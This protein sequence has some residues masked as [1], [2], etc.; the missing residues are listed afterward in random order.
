MKK[1]MLIILDGWGEGRDYPGNAVLAANTP[2]Y[3]TFVANNPS[4][5]LQ[6]SGLSVGLPE[7]QMGNSEVGHLTI[8]AGRV[9]Y[10]E[11]TRINHAFE[12]AEL[13]TNQAFIDQI[14]YCKTQGKPIHLLGLLS[15]GGVH[16]HIQHLFKTIA[17]LDESGVQNIYIHAF[18]DGRDTDPNS[19]LGHLKSLYDFIEDCQKVKIASAIG[20]Y[21]AM[22]RDNRWERTAKAYNLL[23]G[24]EGE[25][26]ENL[27][28]EIDQQ[29][30]EGIT[31]EFMIPFK[32]H[33][34][35]PIQEGDAVLFFNFR[36]DRGRQ[37]TKALTQ[38]D[39]THSEMKPFDSLYFSTFTLYDK[40]FEGVHIIFEPQSLENTLGKVLSDNGLNQ[41]R[42][43]ETEK[44]PHVTFFFN[45]QIEAPY[46][47]EHRF[48]EPSPKVATYDL[49]PEMSAAALNDGVIKAINEEEFSFA[50]VNFANPDMVGHT[51]VFPAIVKACE[52][53]DFE[54]GKLMAE[55]VRLDYQI[56]ITADHGNAEVAINQDNTPN[57]A[58]STNLVRLIMVNSDQIFKSTTGSLADL[59]P[60]ILKM[61][62]V[63]IPK[64][65]TGSILV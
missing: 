4:I 32:T 37:L 14:D 48:L 23:V 63:A 64:E 6:A 19:G 3:D 7:G 53:V 58:H 1:V 24:K 36:T 18:L 46:I 38:K 10:Q 9:V 34:F 40:A 59:A 31:D 13:V 45:G 17:L 8:G 56:L 62:E 61:I 5:M 25:L 39:F 16:S 60:T 55:A 44:Y 65:M 57:T 35:A 28:A 21:Y 20:R 15:D 11:L 12:T 27:L 29:Y 26:A 50:C 54:L 30:A 33:D 47:G 43:A 2:N 42:A 51:G 52:A 49:Q 41:L 22:D